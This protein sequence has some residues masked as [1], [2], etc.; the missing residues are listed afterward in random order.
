MCI[1]DYI[2]NYLKL[3]MQLIAHIKL[4]CSFVMRSMLSSLLKLLHIIIILAVR[5]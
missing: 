3:F 5:Y 1:I 4:F 2:N